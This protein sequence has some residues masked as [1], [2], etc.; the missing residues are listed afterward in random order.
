MQTCDGATALHVASKNG[1]KE[2]VA[3]LLTKNADANKPSD[4]GLLPLH[5]AAQYGHHE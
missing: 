5:V 2:V 4:S 3:L 1:H